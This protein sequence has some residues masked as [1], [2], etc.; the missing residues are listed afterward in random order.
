MVISESRWSNTA[1]AILFGGL[2][3]HFTFMAI[4]I[5]GSGKPEAWL[6]LM[7]AYLIALPVLRIFQVLRV[8]VVGT[9]LKVGFGPFSK[10]IPLHDIQQVSPG[11]YHPSIWRGWG[12]RVQRGGVLFNV[13]GDQGRVVELTLRNGRR[14]LFSAEEPEAVCTAI[15]AQ[16]ATLP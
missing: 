15:R 16:C 1:Y 4:V 11:Q 14:V 10:R 5:P 2:V 9:D 7:G 12:I 8:R 6:P 3:L 13:P